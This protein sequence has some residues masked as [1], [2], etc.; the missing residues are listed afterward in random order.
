MDD[1]RIG[2]AGRWLIAAAAACCVAGASSCNI[3]APVAYAIQGPGK[4]EAQWTLDPALTTVV[5][6]DDP[7]TKIGHRRA[8]TELAEAATNTLLAKSVL[9]DMIDPR[10]AMTIASKE[11]PRWL[12]W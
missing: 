2:R 10:G 6:I 4:V 3:V 11:P 9:T 7:A 8:R 5:F 1:R 12:V